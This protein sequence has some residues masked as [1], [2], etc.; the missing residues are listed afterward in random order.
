M[1]QAL[2]RYCRTPGCPRTV[3]GGGYCAVHQPARAQGWNQ[4]HT[5]IRGP[6]LQRLRMQL[7]ADEPYCRLCKV[8]L[9]TIRDHITPLAEGGT[10]ALENIQP[11]CQACSDTKTQREARYGQDRVR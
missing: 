7:F 1:A 10:D 5:R 2:A 11:L 6:Q 9:A 8:Q 4:D 3:P